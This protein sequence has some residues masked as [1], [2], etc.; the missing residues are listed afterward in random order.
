MIPLFSVDG[1]TLIVDKDKV[2]KHLVKH[3]EAN[4][5]QRWSSHRVLQ[6]PD[7]NTLADPPTT[8]K[9]IKSSGKAISADFIPAEM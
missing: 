7:N 5:Y 1:T 8:A 2:V 6:F 4:H 3:F 9:A